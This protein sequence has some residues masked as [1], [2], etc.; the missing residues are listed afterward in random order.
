MAV[1]DFVIT[2]I[3]APHF[4]CLHFHDIYEHPGGYHPSG[5]LT[6]HS[7]SALARAIRLAPLPEA[8]HP[9]TDTGKRYVLMLKSWDWVLSCC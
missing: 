4:A 6:L 3:N 1:I 7:I 8:A 5:A 9:G 2:S